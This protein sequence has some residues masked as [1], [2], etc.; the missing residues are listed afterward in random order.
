[1][2]F[3]G[4]REVASPYTTVL[5]LLLFPVQRKAQGL[6]LTLGS[7]LFL[8]ATPRRFAGGQLIAECLTLTSSWFENDLCGL[9]NPS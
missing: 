2:L 7:S 9:K 3:L 4:G 6:L 5:D 1:M 8:V